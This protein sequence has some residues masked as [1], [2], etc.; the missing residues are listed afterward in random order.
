MR[1]EGLENQSLDKSA[2]PEYKS[3]HVSQRKNMGPSEALRSPRDVN[4]N[5]NLLNSVFET[6]SNRKI[7]VTKPLEPQKK[8]QYISSSQQKLIIE[9]AAKRKQLA[10]GKI[11]R[12]PNI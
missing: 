9:K 5:L 11:S 6:K 1:V 8:V 3:V 12:N 2:T 4:L 7:T 10:S